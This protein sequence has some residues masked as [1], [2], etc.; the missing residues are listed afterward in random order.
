[1]TEMAAFREE[2]LQRDPGNRITYVDML[3]KVLA[4]ALL[5]F[6]VLNASLVG[7]EILCWKDVNIGVAVALDEGLVVPVV[8]NADR[9][10]LDEIS[11][12]VKDLAARARSGEL[13]PEDYRGG[14]FTLTSG[15]RVETDIIT[16][17]L[18]PPESAILAVGKI[19]PRPTVK[20]GE[21]VVRT[22][23]HLC[24][25]HDHRVVDG[26]PASL[27]QGRVKEIIEDGAQLR[28]VLEG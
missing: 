2:R 23:T 6:P 27:F 28:Q 14:T 18:N 5:E 19:A 7:D 1:M 22:M 3:V 21:L 12:E 10:S 26:V 8:R 15:G 16:P 9:K 13:A 11:R 24:L 25:T 17:I 20:D 4:S